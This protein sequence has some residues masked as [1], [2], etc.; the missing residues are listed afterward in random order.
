MRAPKAWQPTPVGR[1]I[2]FPLHLA[3]RG[4]HCAFGFQKQ[5]SL[6]SDNV[7]E[8]TTKLILFQA[9]QDRAT[10]L[11]VRSSPGTEAAVR[12]RVAETWHDWTGPSPELAPEIIGQIGKLAA[13]TKRPCPKEGLIDVPYSGVRLLWVVRMA[14]TDGDCIL[15]PVEQ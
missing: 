6:M 2:C 5:E 11:V 10:E 3:R 14:S 15:S 13:F 1:P 12:Y 8:R 7:I 4:L 9:Q